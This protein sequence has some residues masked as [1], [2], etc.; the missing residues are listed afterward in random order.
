MVSDHP[1][2][3]HVHRLLDEKI[4][5][6][7]GAIEATHD[8]ASFAESN[9][10]AIRE[11][12]DEEH[13]ARMETLREAARKAALTDH[14]AQLEKIAERIPEW[15]G[16]MR[17]RTNAPEYELTEQ[18]VPVIR[19]AYAHMLSVCD[20]AAAKDKMGFN[21]PDAALARLIMMHDPNMENEATLRLAER[22]LS[23]YKRQLHASF[24]VLFHKP[25]TR[26]K[27]AHTNA[28]SAR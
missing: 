23:R 2:D 8:S 21:R 9:V 5:L 4:R 7:Y 16:R 12:S 26:R 11:V 22:M 25:S 3:L 14:E 6:I 10:P 18:A 15:L 20:G 19:S 24:P 28:V 17:E 13:E 27:N 1:L